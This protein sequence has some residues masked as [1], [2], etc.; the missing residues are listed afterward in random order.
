MSC[1]LLCSRFCSESATPPHAIVVCYV[2]WKH[3]LGKHN[4][5]S[6]FLPCDCVETMEQ[7]SLKCTFKGLLQFHVS[8]GLISFVQGVFSGMSAPSGGFVI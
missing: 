3:T 5:S 8:A 4:V 2:F 1:F 6:G 7:D